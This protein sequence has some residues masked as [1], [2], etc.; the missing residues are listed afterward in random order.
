MLLARAQGVPSSGDSQ[1]EFRLLAGQDRI[2]QGEGCAEPGGFEEARLEGHRGMGML[3]HTGEKGADALIPF[4]KD[5][6][7]GSGL[8]ISYRE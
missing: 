2:Q 1:D 5:W 6:A 8:M 7:S 3:P 4:P